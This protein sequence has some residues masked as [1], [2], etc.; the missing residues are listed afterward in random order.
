MLTSNNQVYIIIE[1]QSSRNMKK[2][3]LTLVLVLITILAF[4]QNLMT[5]YVSYDNKDKLDTLSIEKLDGIY[6]IKA[7]INDDKIIKDGYYKLIE[8]ESEIDYHMYSTYEYG[9]E[10]PNLSVIHKNQKIYKNIDSE[11]IIVVYYCNYFKGIGIIS[12]TDYFLFI[13]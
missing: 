9:F 10:I 5:D 12:D 4:S 6:H 11:E 1:Q 3:I 2:I 7:K 13:K 8:N